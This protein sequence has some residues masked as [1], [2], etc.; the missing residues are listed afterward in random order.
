MAD[1]LERDVERATSVWMYFRDV[2][3][4][5][6]SSTPN[7]PTPPQPHPLHLEQ[8]ELRDVQFARITWRYVCQLATCGVHVV[9]ERC[10][11]S[12]MD[13]T[14]VRGAQ[15]EQ[16]RCARSTKGAIQMCE[17]HNGQCRCARSTMGNADV[18]GAQVV[19]R[20]CSRVHTTMTRLLENSLS[21][22]SG[23]V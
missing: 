15:K 3:S 14:D 2:S 20:P 7:P 6:E 5:I 9:T 19:E 16:C 12:T 23:T 22:G 1:T 13:N 21:T 11:R 18:R 4:W 17:E 10:A 8:P